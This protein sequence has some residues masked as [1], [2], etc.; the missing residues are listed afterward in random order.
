MASRLLS[1]LHR[2]R[3]NE[4]SMD[5]NGNL[6]GSCDDEGSSLDVYE[7]ASLPYSLHVRF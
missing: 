6:R 7:N 1:S 5:K 4:V 2:T 3:S